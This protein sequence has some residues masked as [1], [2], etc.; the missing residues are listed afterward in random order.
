MTFL[1]VAVVVIV[2]PGQD[3]ALTI[4]NTLVGGRRGGVLTAAGVA[5]GQAAW[6]FVA[7]IGNTLRRLR[8]VVEAVAGVVLVALGLRLAGEHR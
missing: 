2:T 7:Q 6:T 3:T 1:L 4:R 5:A 8:R